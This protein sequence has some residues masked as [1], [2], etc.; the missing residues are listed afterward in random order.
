MLDIIEAVKR[1][2]DLWEMAEKF[3]HK[4]DY[5]FRFEIRKEGT[6]KQN[7]RLAEIENRI[8]HYY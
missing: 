4:H 3:H 8:Y 6:D 7:N 1:K 2:S 5:N